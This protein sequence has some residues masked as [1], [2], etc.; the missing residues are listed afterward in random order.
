MCTSS[1]WRR[2]LCGSHIRVRLRVVVFGAGPYTQQ[3]RHCGHA[4]RASDC[5]YIKGSFAGC[6]GD[7]RC[8]DGCGRHRLVREI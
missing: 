2:D 8:C 4:R 1:F 6:G 7:D 5:H 3:Y